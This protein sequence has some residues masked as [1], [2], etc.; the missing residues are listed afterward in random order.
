MALNLGRYLSKEAVHSESTRLGSIILVIL[1][2][3]RGDIESAAE[4]YAKS[5]FDNLNV[6]C[7]TSNPYLGKDSIEP[8]IRNPERG[9]FLLAKTANAGSMD[10]QN[11]LVL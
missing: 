8:F 10:I 7:I 5:A 9:A 6:H 1:D 11:A 3:R 2:A 4:V